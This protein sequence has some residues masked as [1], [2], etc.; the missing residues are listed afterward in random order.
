[1]KPSSAL[2]ALAFLCTAN[3]AE[4]LPKFFAGLLKKDTPI[5]GQI[6]MVLPPA[7][8]DKYVAKVEA[9]A[10][11]DK[12]WFMEFSASAKPG[13][14]LPYHEKIGLTKEEYG[15]YMKLWNQR[16]FKP[17]KED[18]DVMLLL[19]QKSSNIWTIPATGKANSLSTLLYDT[20]KDV[21]L[22][23][24]GELKRIEDIKSD[25]S[26]ILGEWSGQEWKFEEK[27]SL[28]TTKENVA[29]GKYADG[30]FG[31]IIYRVQEMTEAGTLL[32]NKSLVIRFPLSKTST[33]E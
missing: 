26:S 27:T 28:G 12:Q 22:S 18:P 2:L 33:K 30:K 25:P 5:K 15:E 3:A 10:R 31:L 14:P 1:M 16:E 20:K 9:S 21:F 19:R 7:E 6:G 29:F 24:N 8:I 32:L 23:P 17:I 13:L 11:K 4:E